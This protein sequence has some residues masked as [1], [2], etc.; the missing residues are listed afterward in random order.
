MPGVGPAADGNEKEEEG[1]FRVLVSGSFDGVS[2][3][4]AAASSSSST[5]DV[6]LAVLRLPARHGTDLLV[7][8]TTGTGTGTAEGGGDH[9]AA[10]E[11]AGALMRSMLR[12]LRIVDWG[13]FGA[14][15][16]EDEG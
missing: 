11:A 5:V 9:H 2:K 4:R 6:R 7:S 13:L 16:D 10:A 15:D 3:E 12:T 8:L 14:V 1:V